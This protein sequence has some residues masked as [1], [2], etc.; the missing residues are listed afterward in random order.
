MRGRIAQPHM[1]GWCSLI[2]TLEK[3][4]VAIRMAVEEGQPLCALP[5]PVKP[6]Y[7]VWLLALPFEFGAAQPVLVPDE[8]P[9]RSCEA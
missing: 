1:K 8:W 2:S 9:C 3:A 7:T 6:K 5:Q 4:H